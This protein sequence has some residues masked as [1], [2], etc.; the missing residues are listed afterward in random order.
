MNKHILRCADS[1]LRSEGLD[2]RFVIRC[3]A[4][5]SVKVTPRNRG[6]YTAVNRHL[7]RCAVSSLRSE[8]LDQWFDTFCQP[9]DYS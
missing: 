9:L 5:H 1:S 3:Q 6:A 4:M 7:L 8:G 2:Q